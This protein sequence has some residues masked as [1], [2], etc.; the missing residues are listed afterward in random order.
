MQNNEV[1]AC[2]ELISRGDHYSFPNIVIMIISRK[3]G[4]V[5]FH[6]SILHETL[7]DEKSVQSDTTFQLLLHSSASGGCCSHVQEVM[8]CSVMARGAIR[9]SGPPG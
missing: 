9:F 8:S 6:A 4:R 2:C 5:L 3:A 7:C 1:L